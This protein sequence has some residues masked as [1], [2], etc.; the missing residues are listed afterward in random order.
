MQNTTRLI[1]GTSFVMLWGIAALLAQAGSSVERTRTVYVSA[2]DAQGRPAR[3]LGAADFTVKEGGRLAVV[4][5]AGVA[6]GSPT[7]ALV[8]DDMNLGLPEVR[9]A[10]DA[11]VQALNGKAE[12]GLYTASRSFGTLVEPTQN[13]GHLHDGIQRLAPGNP[14]GSFLRRRI[15]EL[16]RAFAAE[17]AQRPVLV[18]VM[19]DRECRIQT[20]PTGS[21]HLDDHEEAYRRMMSGCWDRD[22][23]SNGN[24]Q[25]A[26]AEI[27]ASRAT[28]FGVAARH[29]SNGDHPPILEAA[30]AATG[31][32]LVV[33]L[34]E[35]AL[36]AAMQQIADDIL[37]QYAI[38]YRA[39][40]GAAGTKLQVS[41]GRQGVTVRAP[42]GAGGS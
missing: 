12:I 11:F 6:T 29:R 13:A 30:A 18:V 28:F 32:R 19:L 42:R 17:E 10:L 40:A 36:P 21:S 35:T 31:G 2:V 3:G 34:T 9:S 22:A 16:T 23:G 27:V 8:V 26:V 39:P 1:A 14:E 38:T 24:W 20:T 33:R 15:T 41:A 7:I 5:S 4:T 37:G 25:D